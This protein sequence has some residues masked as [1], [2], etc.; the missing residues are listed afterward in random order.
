MPLEAKMN[1]RVLILLCVA[2]ISG[3]ACAWIVFMVLQPKDS[4]LVYQ[5]SNTPLPPLPCSLNVS[6]CTIT[7][8][9]SVISIESSMRPIQ[10]MRPVTFFIKGFSN[11]SDD[12][13]LKVYGLN[14]EMGTIIT[15][16]TKEGDTYQ[17]T[18]NLGTCSLQTMRY[19]LALYEGT[20]PLGAFIDFDVEQ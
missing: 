19:R 12:L 14:M 16:A 15:Q 5:E 6:A 11:L 9:D 17:A 1:M 18:I 8:Q 20:K 2:L 10:A 4:Q 13:V 3:V 7:Y